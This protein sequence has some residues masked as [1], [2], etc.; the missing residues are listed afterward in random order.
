[1]LL[2]SVGLTSHIQVHLGWSECCLL[3]ML[4]Q[5]QGHPLA[6]LSVLTGS[7]ESLHGSDVYH[8]DGLIGRHQRSTLHPP[9]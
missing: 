3:A 6:R 4:L 9:G 1:M 8:R 2:A 7:L 5:L